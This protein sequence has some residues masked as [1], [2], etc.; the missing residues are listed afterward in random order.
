MLEHVCPPGFLEALLVWWR[1]FSR[2]G[3]TLPFS[4]GKTI[5]DDY[6]ATIDQR[7]KKTDSIIFT[8]K[9]HNTST[10]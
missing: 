5:D 9:K 6:F 8:E 4:V 10:T 1:R 3:K 7:Q 2:P